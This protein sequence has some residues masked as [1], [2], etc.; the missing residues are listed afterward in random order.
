MKKLQVKYEPFD[1]I[2]R[3]WKLVE[4]KEGGDLKS[5]HACTEDTIL[6][7]DIHA[8]LV[9]IHFDYENCNY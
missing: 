8:K 1:P 9:K 5:I 7:K 6:S 2:S 4:Q 3:T